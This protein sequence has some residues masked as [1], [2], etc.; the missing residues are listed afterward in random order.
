MKPAHRRC[1]EHSLHLGSRAVSSFIEFS[2]T[3]RTTASS[4]ERPYRFRETGLRPRLLRP[5]TLVETSVGISTV[6]RMAVWS[7]DPSSIELSGRM[8][9]QACLHYAANV[10]AS[11]M[12]KTIPS[13]SA[14]FEPFD[15]CIRPLGLRLTPVLASF[16]NGSFLTKEYAAV[17]AVQG[18][19]IFY[20]SV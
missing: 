11:S 2:I 16:P 8:L 20:T 13:N 10:R 15:R 3:S 6:G 14:S 5:T 12:A 9:V 4:A 1:G 17:A 19:G 18:C 7:S